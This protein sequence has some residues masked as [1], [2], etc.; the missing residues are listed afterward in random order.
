MILGYL[1]IIR[2][3]KEVKKL[4]GFQGSIACCSQ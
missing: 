1:E 3:K 2:E 4:I